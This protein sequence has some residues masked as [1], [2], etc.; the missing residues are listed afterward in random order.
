[1]REMTVYQLRL[2]SGKYYVGLTE[3]LPT[4][5][6]D[7]W[8]GQGA[9]W[10]RRYRPLEVLKTQPGDRAL[11]DAL[12][13]AMM[14]EH[15]M[16][17]VRG[18]SWCSLELALMPFPLAKALARLPRPPLPKAKGWESSMYLGELI[19]IRKTGDG[20]SA[21]VSGPL[22]MGRAI[23]RR[24]FSAGEARAKAEAWIEGELARSNIGG[25]YRERDDE[26]GVSPSLGGE[27]RVPSLR[28]EDGPE[29]AVLQTCL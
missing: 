5:I 2:E 22:S 18:G 6:A 13:I 17:N 21:R 1:M 8:L 4:R 10:T 15:G 28:G 16:E 24:G 12:T 11:E 20:F 3:D 26:R 27:G 9:Q 14:V 7:H 29:D 23:S 25:V 19:V